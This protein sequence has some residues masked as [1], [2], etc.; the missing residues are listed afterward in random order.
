M[1]LKAFISL[2]V[3]LFVFQTAFSQ[4]QTGISYYG[5]KGRLYAYWGWN[6][7][8]YSK[9]NI[10][11]SGSGYDF[12]LSK[13]GAK[14]RPSPFDFNTYF[15]PSNITIPQYNFR[16]G[17]FIS[18]HYNVSFG[19]DHMKYVVQDMQA[20]IINGSIS[21]TGTEYDGEYDDGEVIIKSG[22]LEFEHTDGLN[23][24]NL[25]IRRFDQIFN[26]NKVQIGFTEGIELGLV[27]PKTNTLLINNERYDEFHLAGWGMNA[28]VGVNIEL[29]KYFFIQP[30]FKGGFISMPDIRTTSS[31]LDKAKQNFWFTQFNVVFGFS[32]NLIKN[33]I[34]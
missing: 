31:E 20:V 24:G 26:Y 22:F 33:K 27:I 18:D 29:F 19:I 16:L 14:D 28:I 5:H 17:Y 8:W 9:S 32:L 13:V 2:S 12:T 7:A 21:G 30:E 4:E 6:G 11:F 23:Y 3:L 10:T 15:N 34:E 1:Q 25:G